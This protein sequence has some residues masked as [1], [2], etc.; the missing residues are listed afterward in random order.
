[1]WTA[2]ATILLLAVCAFVRLEDG[3][4]ALR[5]TTADLF[6]ETDLLGLGMQRMFI[7]LIGLFILGSTGPFQRLVTPETAAQKDRTWLLIGLA[8][9]LILELMSTVWLN[10]EIDIAVTNG[11][12]IVLICSLFGGWRWGVGTSLATVIFYVLSAIFAERPFDDMGHAAELIRI[13]VFEIALLVMVWGSFVLGL[14]RPVP[15]YQLKPHHLF[16]IGAMFEWFSSVLAFF[17]FGT[18]FTLIDELPGTIITGLV[19]ML[20]GFLVQQANGRTAAKRLAAAEGAQ[21]QA[22]LKAL[23][24]QINP[25]F[26]FNALST[27]KYHART[28]PETAYELLDDL[29]EVFH[30]ALRSEPFVRLEDELDMVKAYL[31]IEQAR[32]RERLTVEFEIDQAVDLD[33]QI[34]A[35]VLQPLVE[36]AVIHGIAPKASGGTIRIKA[37]QNGS[38]YD[39][40]IEDDGVGFDPADCRPDQSPSHHLLS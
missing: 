23:R 24:A 18:G 27:I 14:W 31:A 21:T 8:L 13:T 11:L 2:F 33:A 28:E 17:V 7:P 32:L 29:S 25:H 9:I 1:M 6:F 30:T 3:S 4:Q 39:V 37:V 12:A 22:E 19:L 10:A 16:I 34:P 38:A 26:L 35:L 5:F 36:N 15:F 20:F 40:M